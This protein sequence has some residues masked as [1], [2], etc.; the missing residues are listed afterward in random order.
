[1]NKVTRQGFQTATAESSG[2]SLGLTQASML[3]HPTN[4][5]TN[6]FS[7]NQDIR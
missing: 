1:V 7:N 3:V 2:N 4:S 5:T 6:R